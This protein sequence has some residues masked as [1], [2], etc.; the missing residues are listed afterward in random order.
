MK[1]DSNLQVDVTDELA[2]DPAISH[3]DIGVIVREGVVTL[4]GTLPSLAEKHAVEDAVRRVEGVKGLAVE[5]D[6]K[7]LPEHERSD[8]DIAMAVRHALEWSAQVPAN[9][10]LAT[11]EKGYIT[12]TG[13]VA[14]GYQR[15]AA[16]RAVRGLIG[17]RGIANQVHVKPLV[18]SG[19]VEQ[20]IQGAL[21]RHAERDAKHV[22]VRVDGSKVIVS[23][24]VHSL[25]ERDAVC[26][27]AWS[28]PGVALVV[29]DLVVF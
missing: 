29:D 22:N 20:R 26:G 6:V 19:Q 9:A 4:T 13:H 21:A 5:L 27:A 23:G 17:V 15:K 8:A 3:T 11:V 28:S 24:R 10:V 14:W 12:L 16:E 18:T 7:L 25:A 2:W 1:T